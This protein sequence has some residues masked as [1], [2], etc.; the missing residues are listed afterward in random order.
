MRGRKKYCNAKKQAKFREKVL[1][2]FHDDGP[3][4]TK[5]VAV[6][7]AGAVGGMARKKM[8]TTLELLLEEGKLVV[9]YTIE[10][11]NG[12]ESRVFGLPEHRKLFA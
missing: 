1:R 3:G 11:K 5:E 8:R 12:N 4:T 10:D 2:S 6:T 7:V 9:L